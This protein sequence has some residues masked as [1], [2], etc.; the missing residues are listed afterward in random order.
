AHGR[1]GQVRDRDSQDVALAE[2]TVGNTYLEID[3]VSVV[4]QASIGWSVLVLEGEGF[5]LGG[6]VHYCA[7]QVL[8]RLPGLTA[9]LRR[10]LSECRHA[11]RQAQQERHQRVL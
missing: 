10:I 8:L 3:L 11:A 1:V 4:V 9:A 5:D 2:G 6:R 7:S